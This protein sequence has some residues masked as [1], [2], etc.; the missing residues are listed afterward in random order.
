V[1]LN[2]KGRQDGGFYHLSLDM[3]AS[4]DAAI[5]A[6]KMDTGASLFQILGILKAETTVDSTLEFVHGR[7]DC[8][9]FKNGSEIPSYEESPKTNLRAWY[10]K[11]PGVQA[12]SVSCDQSMSWRQTDLERFRSQP[13]VYFRYH[14][15][16]HDDGA[17]SVL[18]A[19]MKL[20][21]A[22]TPMDTLKVLQDI[23]QKHGSCVFQLEIEAY[24]YNP[25]RD[26]R[27]N[28]ISNAPNRL[29]FRNGYLLADDSGFVSASKSPWSEVERSLTGREA[30]ILSLHDW[31]HA[32]TQGGA[33]PQ[34]RAGRLLP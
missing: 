30:R 2:W 9:A 12:K 11:L 3:P 27:Y 10:Q 7:T 21:S 34:P 19:R 14:A 16:L 17:Y 31:Y 18:E 13:G 1:Y 33:G 22:V 29:V 26:M 6:R 32:H 25:P 28:V 5:F 24:Q 15:D 20:E 8:F 4:T 23:R